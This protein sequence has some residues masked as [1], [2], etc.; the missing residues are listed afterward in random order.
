[1]SSILLTRIVCYENLLG[2]SHRNSL[3]SLSALLKNPKGLYG[4]LLFMA[5]VFM[6]VG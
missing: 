1:M 3:D 6:G 4:F 2:A 5:F